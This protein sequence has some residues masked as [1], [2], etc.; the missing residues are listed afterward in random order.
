MIA[1]D[2][3]SPEST[4][5][6]AQ[7]SEPYQQGGRGNGNW[8]HFMVIAVYYRP[9]GQ[10]QVTGHWRAGD[11]LDRAPLV[12]RTRDGRRVTIAGAVMEP[13]LNSVCEARGQRRLV[14]PDLGQLELEGCIHAAR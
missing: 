13:P 12:L 1:S 7:C 10:T 11:W 2:V 8:F 9:D 4:V 14:I 3:S 5:I 6:C